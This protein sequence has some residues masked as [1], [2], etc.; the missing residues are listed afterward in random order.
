MA[1]QFFIKFSTIK[2]KIVSSI[3][4]LFHEYGQR[5]GVI[6]IGT[7]QGWQCFI[8]NCCF[9]LLLSCFNFPP[10]VVNIFCPRFLTFAILTTI[11]I[12]VSLSKEKLKYFHIKNN[13]YVNWFSA[14]DLSAIKAGQ[15]AKPKRTKMG[16]CL[17][18]TIVQFE[19][20]EQSSLNLVGKSKG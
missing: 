9:S 19:K 4:K 20:A 3:A 12:L 15:D 2:F 13:M 6:L 7:P 18:D 11:L 17:G 14:A 1:Q 8:N 16:R 5:G 10:F